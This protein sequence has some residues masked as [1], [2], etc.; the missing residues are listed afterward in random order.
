MSDV[1]QRGNAV[2]GERIFRR[3]ELTCLKCH[4]IAG[5]GGQVGPDLAG[6]GASAPVDYLIES[7]LLPNKA[8]KENYHTLLVTTN[9]G[10]LFTGIKVRESATELVLRDIEGRDLAIPARSIEERGMGRSLMPDGLA[11]GLTRAEFADL[12][13]FLAE[14]GKVGPFTPGKAR[15]VRRWQVL[16]PTPDLRRLVHERGLGP[17]ITG[18]SELAWSPAYSTV[19]GVLPLD[20]VPVVSVDPGV[21]PSFVRCQVEA[22]AAGKV[23]L[24][25]TP[26]DGLTLWIDRT[27]TEARPV[28]VLDLEAGTHM[29]TV[30]IDRSRIHE[31]RLE[32]QDVTGSAARARAVT[33]R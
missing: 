20:D 11:D 13:R 30:A 33:G 18:S 4:A 26:A 16:E 1:S 3:K 21:S 24:K 5:A 27:P 29:V 17:A 23:R 15:V 8:V 14:L 22:S 7:I 2:R 25:L 12:V 31:I 32:V 10:R 6:I 9:D 19:A 28:M